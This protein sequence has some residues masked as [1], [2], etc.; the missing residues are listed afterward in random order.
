MRPEQY[1]G[2]WNISNLR[3]AALLLAVVACLIV[4]LIRPAGAGQAQDSRYFVYFGT[5]PEGKGVYMCTFEPAEMRFGPVKLVAEIERATW[6]AL[7]P[8]KRILYAV[9]E[10][11][12]EGKSN[13]EL[14][15]FAIDPV[16]GSLKLLNRV[17]SEA[18][19]P[20]HL[21]VDKN[22]KMLAVANYGGGG[23]TAFRLNSDGSIGKR[24]ALIQ[25]SGSGVHERQ[26]SP[27]PH[28]V[29]LSPDNR[30]LFVADLGV[31]KVYSYHVNAKEGLLVP[32]TPAFVQVSPGSGPR[33]LA[34]HPLGR[35]AYLIQQMGSRIS[36]FSYD[37]ARGSLA[38][39][40]TVGTLPEG[41]SG[42]NSG[43]EIAVSRSGRYLYASNRGDD[44][45]VVFAIDPA[46]GTLRTIQRVPTQGKMPHNFGIDPAG[47][48]LFAANRDSSDI[49][50]F[51]INE[52]T[53]ELSPAGKSLSVPSPVCVIF[54]PANPR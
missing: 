34:F 33:H 43:A 37:A 1:E 21:A 45:I 8:N 13:G 48:F 49:I 39:I 29:M 14:L 15:S 26:T 47:R 27:H 20:T 17:S 10:L 28:G 18:G 46:K 36:A 42:T 7:H 52:S 12:N 4:A 25:H 9:N 23:V 53:G 44:S 50:V 31:D 19:G 2:K 24:A 30:F 6:I 32:N 35:F 3:K 41:F 38:E 54:V 51:Q 16:S 5:R 40:Q 11:G 22:G